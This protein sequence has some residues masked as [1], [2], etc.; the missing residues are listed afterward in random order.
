LVQ[1]EVMPPSGFLIK[2]KSPSRALE[3]SAWI[4]KMLDPAQLM[5][6]YEGETA[7]SK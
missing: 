1:A 7:E 3:K 6:G 4:P 2:K 5:A